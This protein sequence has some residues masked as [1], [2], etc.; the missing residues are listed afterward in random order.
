MIETKI[1]YT[2]ALTGLSP[3][4]IKFLKKSKIHNNYIV[5]VDNK[6]PKKKGFLDKFIKIPMAKAAL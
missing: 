6:N 2:C 1:L 5:G 4:N 3:L